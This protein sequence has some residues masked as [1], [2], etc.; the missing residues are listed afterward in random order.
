MERRTIIELVTLYSLEPTVRDIYV[1]GPTDR[2]FVKAVLRRIGQNS[3]QVREIDLVEVSTDDLVSLGLDVGSRQRVI[4]LAMLLEKSAVSDLFRQVVCIADADDDAGGDPTI[5]GVL[6]VYTDVTSMSVYAFVPSYIQWYLDIEVLDFPLSGP[7]T[8]AALTPVLR[9][10]Q[11]VRR[12]FRSLGIPT[13]I[14]DPTRDCS[15]NGNA[16]A[17]DANRFLERCANKAGVYEKLKQIRDLLPE[18]NRA[19]PN[20]PRHWVHAEDFLTLFHWL[21]VK[22]RG[23]GNTVASHLLGRTLLLGIPQDDIVGWP[24]FKAVVARLEV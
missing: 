5:T 15:L 7:D 23:A 22:V 11:V 12:S 9:S 1:E 17:F 10:I 18:K 24:M 13:D 2:A 20:D 19:L 21:I 16:I 4:A 8:L 3:V 6:L 14:V